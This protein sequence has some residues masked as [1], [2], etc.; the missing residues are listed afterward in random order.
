MISNVEV[1]SPGN[2]LTVQ[3]L[4]RR[5]SQRFGV[6]VSGVLDISAA[7]TANRLVGNPANSAMLEAT[8]GGVSLSFNSE[9][10]IAITGAEVNVD[11]DGFQ[12]PIWETLILPAEAV[13]TLSI[14]STGLYSYISVAG[15]IDTPVV[16]GSRST[17]VAS[18][19]GGHEGR[20]LAAGDILRIGE[21]IDVHERPRAGTTASDGVVPGS[22]DHERPIRVTSAPQFDVFDD[23]AKSTF[24]ES[25]F[26]IS[27]LT[28]RQGARLDGASIH[29]IDGKHDIVSD[30]AYMGAIQ[31]PS[32]GKPIVLL[33]DRQPTGGYA[34]IA[35]V[36]RADLPSVVQRTPGSNIGF[37]LV[38]IEK[39]QELTRGFL[40][41]IHHEPLVE[42]ASVFSSHLEID[43][44]T[45]N[46]E[47]VRP[48]KVEDTM[49]S[50]GIIYADFR[51]GA[52]L[53]VTVEASYGQTHEM[54]G[55][56]G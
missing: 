15:G 28:D 44:K 34:K 27:N 50:D 24:F 16:L 31:V 33:A 52:E 53:A 40:N 7:V 43:G 8:F 1:V 32:D 25:I 49:D 48:T 17:H 51:D 45:Y 20:T 3:D 54:N 39:A 37:E 41:L 14:P 6:S 42:P 18:G 9:T 11:V 4:G 5:G 38:S 26:T 30:P 13:L 29:A 56:D 2:R 21:E 55:T 12:M 46:V 35:S 47:I 23:D 36:V 22:N 10:R 19:I